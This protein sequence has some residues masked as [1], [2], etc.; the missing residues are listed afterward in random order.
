MPNEKPRLSIVIPVCNEEGNIPELYERLSHTLHKTATPYEII[1]IE[2]GSTD[3]TFLYLA[4]LHQRDKLVRV[5]KFRRNSGKAAALAAGFANA[6][7]EIII[8]LDGDLQDEPEL[9]PQFI[10]KINAGYDLVCGWR[11]PRIDSVKKRFPSL[12][13]NTLTIL[14]SGVRIHDFNCGYKAYRRE[15]IKKLPLY[16][17]LYRYLPLLVHWQGYKVTEIRVRHHPRKS[18]CT[19]YSSKRLLYGVFDFVT[20]IFL[21]RYLTHPLHLFGQFGGIL[22]LAGL[23][24]NI[25]IANLKIRYGNIQHREPLLILG[26]FLTVVGIQFISTGLLGEMITNIR[27]QREPLYSI[28][29]KLPE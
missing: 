4:K 20:I 16:G 2:D 21:Y 25:Y 22:T 19:K 17:G 26:V 5:I 24:I 29:R 11:K 12:I 6:Q 15:V 27:Q 23:G 9:L 10:N 18:G 3:N 7:G 13:F 28:E 8:T 14:L 1:F